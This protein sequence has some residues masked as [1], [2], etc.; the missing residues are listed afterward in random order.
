[1]EDIASVD[2]AVSGA[3]RARVVAHAAAIAATVS[4]AIVATVA[5]RIATSATTTT[6]TVSGTW[7][8]ASARTRV[9]AGKERAA[10]GV[11]REAGNGLLAAVRLHALF[12]VE[13][14]VAESTRLEIAAHRSARVSGI[15]S[16]H[17]RIGARTP[18][19]RL[20]IGSRDGR[21]ARDGEEREPET[22]DQSLSRD[23]FARHSVTLPALAEH[24]PYRTAPNANQAKFE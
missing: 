8:H 2:A 20:R 24:V 9:N 7:G 1:M 15:G 12:A 5:A 16:R 18:S 17:L 6:T 22:D 11:V 10:F 3:R 13:T 14:A 23:K 19:G 4:A 21:C